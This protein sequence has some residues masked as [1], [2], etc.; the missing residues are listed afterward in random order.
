MKKI[1]LDPLAMAGI[2]AGGAVGLY[3]AYAAKANMTKG[4]GIVI[5]ACL[6]GYFAVSL[7]GYLTKQKDLPGAA[8]TDTV[9][10]ADNQS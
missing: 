3:G 10:T 5:G 7:A 4:A 8:S 9:A 6:I 1:T 2:T